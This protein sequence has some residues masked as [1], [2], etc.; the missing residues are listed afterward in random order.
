MSQRK[1]DPHAPEASGDS[2]P[3]SPDSP[4]SPGEAPARRGVSRRHVLI[5]GAAT[6]VTAGVAGGVGASLGSGGSTPASATS[7][8]ALTGTIKDVKHVVI[9]MQE[10]RSFD[11]YLGALPGVRGF[12]DKQ[13]LE[14]PGG[15]DIFHQ[16]DPARPDGGFL[17]PFRMDSSL[18]NGQNA[19]D[20]DHSWE[21]GHKAL[22]GGAW[23]GWVGAKTE[24][25]MGY[26]TRDDIPYQHALA[27]AFTVCD[28]YFCSVLGPTTPNRLYQWAGNID[29][30]GGHGGPV[31][32]NPA[33]YIGALSYGTYAEKLF[34]AGVSFR[35]YAN[36]EVGDSGLHPYLGDYGDNPLWLFS[37]YHDALASTDPARQKL[38]AQAGLHD[39][40]KPASDRGL[41][42]SYLLRDFIADA[43]AGT[44][45]TVSYV[46]APY[47]WSEHPAASPDYGG[48]YVNQV[49]QAV[50][51]N[52]TLW[53][54]TAVLVNYDENDGFFDH[55]VPPLPEPG[56][57][58]EF[59]GG[60]PIGLG[61]RVP[62]TVVSPWSRGGWVNSQVFDHTSVI[63]FLEQVTGVRHDGIS[64]WRRTV[65]GDLTSAF[66]FGR[67]DFS[68]PSNKVVPSLA[69]TKALTLA[70]DA[71]NLKP[72]VPLPLPGAQALP[73]Q[74][75]S[76]RH[77]ALPYRQTANATIDIASGNVT[78]TLSN[79][80]TVGVNHLVYPNKVLPFAATPYTLAAGGQATHTW[81][82]G[83]TPDRTYDL[84]VYGP[85]RFL[86][87]FAG[88][89]T[90]TSPVVSADLVLGRTPGLKL[91]L[92]NPS[93][94]PLAFTLAANDFVT[95]TQT[96]T[97]N[98]GA[99]T[100]VTWPVDQWGYYDVVVTSIG[101]FR[102]RFAGRVG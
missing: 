55:V 7:D 23:N 53:A 68:I 93:R 85:D 58:G 75:G 92:G 16:P 56:T 65:A 45:P 60:L 99:S 47:G 21:G 12:G 37:Q 76:A 64:A 30:S 22:A 14:Y 46:V 54:Q 34:G 96:V 9:L 100:T 86:R 97:V 36:D 43:K 11:H 3:G 82:G 69:A 17:L 52:P 89:A 83:T 63:Q 80:G 57:A 2:V 70:A 87:R 78:V 94:G 90:G 5:A 66:D 20:L 10:N 62:M 81:P 24:R 35:T 29:P 71:D 79:K 73:T 74:T 61:T 25:T 67:P 49:V 77:R 101:G 50:L 59:V 44:L 32:S 18:Y 8:T 88:D 6:A 72:P 48:H 39:G 98:A 31:T 38:A 91:A 42:V 26:F 15:G 13:A 28:H 33:D 84:S 27:S 102:Y 41:D 95:K 19:G 51:A 4:G 40:W 1:S